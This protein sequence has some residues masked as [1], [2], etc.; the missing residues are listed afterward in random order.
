[1]KVSKNRVILSVVIM[2]LMVSNITYGINFSNTEKT[3]VSLIQ[4]EISNKGFKNV[5]DVDTRSKTMERYEEDTDVKYK[6][7][8][9]D[10]DNKTAN[11]IISG[12]FELNRIKNTFNAD[13][14]IDKIQ[15]ESG[16]VLYMGSVEGTINI[17]GKKRNIDVAFDRLEDNTYFAITINNLES[18]E[19]MPI[20]AFG[21]SSISKKILE[22]IKSKGNEKQINK[23]TSSKKELLRRSKYREVS[24]DWENKRLAV[25]ASLFIDNDIYNDGD[26]G[27]MMHLIAT[28]ISEIEDSFSNVDYVFPYK[29]I[30]ELTSMDRESS[31]I[32]YAPAESH[33][34]TE[35]VDII[36]GLLNDLRVP[37]IVIS[38][39]NLIDE[40]K[41]VE[42]EYDKDMY[43]RK[44]IV[45]VDWQ[46][47]FTDVRDGGGYPIEYA[48]QKD[49]DATDDDF[50][51][52]SRVTFHVF[53]KLVS[54]CMLRI[55][56]LS[57]QI[58]PNVE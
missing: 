34:S 9:E 27:K 11:L 12:E 53:E 1:M 40:L 31:I 42:V 28:D 17:A 41:E 23:K 47:D 33:S 26:D 43:K 49:N 19:G 25:L 55:G 4:S 22:D 2:M 38:L 45:Y 16:V 35:L 5:F 36:G 29:I 52:E 20:I 51:A 32:A 58:R 39:L 30:A 50:L 44:H 10:L 18:K 13:G 57:D 37:G 8:V 21:E 56:F 15:L 54:Q 48:I 6:V 3:R 24:N 46:C 14:E 7:R